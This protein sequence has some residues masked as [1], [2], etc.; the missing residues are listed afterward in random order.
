[1]NNQFIPAERLR[2]FISSA[3]SDEGIFS[4][5]NVRQ[6]VKQYL[7]GGDYETWDVFF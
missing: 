4:W 2:V 6:R 7:G 1:M 5:S 3:Q